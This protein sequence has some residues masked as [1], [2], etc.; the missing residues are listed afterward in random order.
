M[1]P[2]YKLWLLCFSTSEALPIRNI[3]HD[4]ADNTMRF[5]TTTLFAALAAGAVATA[6]ESYKWGRLAK[7][8]PDLHHSGAHH[9]HAPKSS[10]HAEARGL[11][12]FGIPHLEDYHGKHVTHAPKATQHIARG[13]TEDW[14]KFTKKV[15][16]KLTKT[17][18]HVEH[19]IEHEF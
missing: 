18:G 1:C 11:K 17:A 9:T 6:H 14:E 19:D 8:T 5:L 2:F 4:A 16:K 3:S 15:G 10:H 13:L 7:G 12:D